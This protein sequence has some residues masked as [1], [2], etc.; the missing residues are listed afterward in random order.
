MAEKLEIAVYGE[1]HGISKAAKEY[2]VNKRNIRIW[3]AKKDSLK[4]QLM[5]A[6]RPG[7]IGR[8]PKAKAR[9]SHRARGR[10]PRRVGFYPHSNMIG[11]ASLGASI[12]E[13]TVN[14]SPP[15]PLILATVQ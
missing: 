6:T 3:I 12:R 10:P 9:K 14:G 11:G 4:T 7:A 2:D 15:P 1:E 8:P 5:T 13:N